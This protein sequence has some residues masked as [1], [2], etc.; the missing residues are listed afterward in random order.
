MSSQVP[1]LEHYVGTPHVL[2][3]DRENITQVEDAI[4]RA[5]PITVSKL[6]VAVCNC[7]IKYSISKS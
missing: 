1:Y 6:S 2:T 3:V 5:I 4:K 7:A